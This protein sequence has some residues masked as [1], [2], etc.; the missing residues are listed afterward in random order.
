MDQTEGAS[1]SHLPGSTQADF[2]ITNAH[3]VHSQITKVSSKKGSAKGGALRSAGPP[4]QAQKT[5]SN[6]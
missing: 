2:L 1:V 5:G 4:A 6:E 3:A